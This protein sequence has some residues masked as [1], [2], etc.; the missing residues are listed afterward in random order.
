MDT[1]RE[2]A[3][4]VELNGLDV[5]CTTRM[6]IGTP[7]GHVVFGAPFFEARKAA[8]RTMV[9][10]GWALSDA[11]WC[12]TR[13]DYRGCGDSEGSFS[14]FSLADWAAD[15]QAIWESLPALTGIAPTGLLGLRTGA[16]IA[17]AVG[18]RLPGLTCLALW[19]PV[20]D[21]TRYL[22]EEFRRKQIQN[23]MTTG[24][25]RTGRNAL[26]QALEAGQTIDLDGYPLTP[27]LYHDLLDVKPETLPRTLPAQTP[28]LVVENSRPSMDKT[29]PSPLVAGMINAGLKPDPRYV[30]YPPFWNLLGLVDLTMLITPTVEWF[31]QQANPGAPR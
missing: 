26:Q 8:H 27:R 13:F 29:G 14:N 2:Q 3:R 22:D 19:E 4:F 25:G 18:S 30:A 28:T 24:H 7:V 15:L 23:M 12:V 11:G 9:E 31:R 20:C 6:P 16:T 5:F 10:T 1:P 17:C 21:G